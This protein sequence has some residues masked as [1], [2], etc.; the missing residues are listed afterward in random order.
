MVHLVAELMVFL[1]GVYWE[2]HSDEAMEYLQVTLLGL[3]K[4]VKLAKLMDSSRVC[5]QDVM[6]ALTKVHGRVDL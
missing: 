3:E 5:K 4:A 6:M 2:L 1:E